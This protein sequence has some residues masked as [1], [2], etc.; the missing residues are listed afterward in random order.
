MATL[1]KDIEPDIDL[2]EEIVQEAFEQA[3]EHW[4][5][6]GTPDRPGAWLLTTARRRAMQPAPRGP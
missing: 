1:K 3:L 5:A 6:T 2:A 4:P